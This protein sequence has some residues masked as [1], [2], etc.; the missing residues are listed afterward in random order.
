MRKLAIWVAVGMLLLAGTAEAQRSRVVGGGGGGGLDGGGGLTT[1]AG[2]GGGGAVFGAGGP[3]GGGGTVGA[4]APVTTTPVNVSPSHPG[5]GGGGGA[6]LSASFS[7]PV[8]AYAPESVSI[9]AVTPTKIEAG[10]L[11]GRL[12]VETTAFGESGSRLGD[13]VAT[14]TDSTGSITV[15]PLPW[16]IARSGVNASK[17]LVEVPIPAS[18]LSTPKLAVVTLKFEFRDENGS[19]MVFRITPPAFFQVVAPVPPPPR[20]SAL[21]MVQGSA[22]PAEYRKVG[23]QCL[24]QKTDARLRVCYDVYMKK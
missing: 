8:A 13:V 17:W 12:L 11:G 22:A 3:V 16:S 14:L 23:T 20:N 5:G 15:T 4:S 10:S 1:S 7:A 19:P 21:L 2:A 24:S 18:F 9:L 6:S